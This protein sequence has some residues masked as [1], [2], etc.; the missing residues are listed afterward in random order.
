MKLRILTLLATSAMLSSTANAQLAP[1]QIYVPYYQPQPVVIAN[2]VQQTMAW[3]GGANSPQLAMADLNR[4]GIKDLVIFD[5]NAGPR[6]MINESPTPGSPKYVYHPE[7]QQNFPPVY[8]YCK[9]IDYN[10]DGIEDIVHYGYSSYAVYKG[11]VSGGRLA[12]DNTNFNG[13]NGGLY[14]YTGG[15]GWVNA[16]TPNGDLPAVVDIDGDGDLDFFGMD[17][18]QAFISFYRGCQHEDGLPTDSIKICLKNGCWGG[19]FQ[20]SIGRLWQLAVSTCQSAG[21]TCKTTKTTH[22]SNTFTTVDIDGDGDYDMFNGNSNFTDIQL[23]INGKNIYGK[24]TII[25][26][27]TMWSVAGSPMKINTFPAAYW[28]DLDN[29]G[30]KDLAFAPFASIAENYNG[31]QFYKN[32]GTNSSPS[33]QYK[34]DTLFID[35]MIDVGTAASPVFYD[36]NKDG[37]LDMFVGSD[38]YYVPATGTLKSKVAYYMNTAASSTSTPIFEL[39]TKDFMNLSSYNFN[40]I[41]LAFGDLDNDGKDDMVIGRND[42]NMTFF[43]NNA[44]SATIQPV[45]QM[46]LTLND[47]Y[48][49][50]DVGDYATP[51]IYDID[52]DGRK[53]LVSGSMYGKLFYYK[54]V[55]PTSG[56]V[57]LNKVTDTL[58]GISIDEGGNFFMY[59]APFIGRIDNTGKD[60]LLLGTK[61]GA[62]YRFDGISAHNPTLHYNRLDSN[63]N[64]INTGDRPRPFVAD[65]NGDG[66][67]EMAIGNT[68]G[69][70]FLYKQIFNVEVKN[71]FAGNNNITVYPN[72][73][74]DVINVEWKGNFN[75]GDVHVSLISVTGQKLYE[76]TVTGT[77]TQVKIDASGITPG[78]YYCIVQSGGNKSVAPVTIIK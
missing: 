59:T 76:S 53:D 19:M 32:M 14:Y 64:L 18:N 46:Q 44:G 21:V 23:L 27:D 67:Y 8:G 78:V 2:G 74:K 5:K 48:G 72:P 37:K 10:G 11:R 4:D 35:N 55:T 13:K 34:T 43:K 3:C 24:D 38:G 47:Q 63:Y 62:I 61:N 33:F 40:G 20:T 6:T 58:G 56:S 66:F 42:G 75:D 9:L 51:F 31:I 52:S 39:Q 29:D 68:S 7:F 1:G 54:N 16:Y 69:G 50:L 22:G 73:A 30:K 12:F 71:V 25:A 28:L 60:Y 65:L 36:Y 45:W 26:Q 77:N 70:I 15:S 57:T 17:I 49:T 41:S